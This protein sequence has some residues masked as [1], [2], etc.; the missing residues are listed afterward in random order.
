MWVQGTQGF[1]LAGAT[2]SSTAPAAQ[3]KKAALKMKKLA[4]CRWL[5]PEIPAT[6]E[7][8]IGRIVV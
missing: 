3:K 1:T 6:Q 2:Q 8:E 5:T 7:A 4:G